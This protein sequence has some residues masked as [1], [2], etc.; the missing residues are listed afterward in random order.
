[1]GLTTV[2]RYCAACDDSSIN[3]IR[4]WATLYIANG[5]TSVATSNQQLSED[6]AGSTTVNDASQ[7]DQHSVSDSNTAA[8]VRPTVYP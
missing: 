2:Q 3:D 7:D 6:G 5:K 8:Y 1:M 4:T